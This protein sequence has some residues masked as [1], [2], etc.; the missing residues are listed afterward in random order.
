MNAA[1]VYSQALSGIHLTDE[2][3][4]ILATDPKLSLLYAI[5]VLGQRFQK[6]EQGIYA[7]PKL[8]NVYK[9]NFGEQLSTPVPEKFSAFYSETIKNYGKVTPIVEDVDG[10][11]TP[12]VQAVSDLGDALEKKYDIDID[13]L[14]REGIRTLGSKIEELKT[15]CINFI[16]ATNIDAEN[17]DYLIK[18]FVRVNKLPEIFT[19]ISTVNGP[20]QRG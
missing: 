15:F 19:I 8:A 10:E 12:L 7:N 18:K 16:K 5:K 4:K 9:R 17:K 11:M 1:Q 3:E 14:T 2:Q 13:V 20:L 6:G